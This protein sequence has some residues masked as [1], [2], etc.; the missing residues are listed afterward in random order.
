MYNW[1]G[2][3]TPNLKMFVKCISRMLGDNFEFRILRIILGQF[4]LARY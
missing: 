4:I 3:F 2:H 1:P